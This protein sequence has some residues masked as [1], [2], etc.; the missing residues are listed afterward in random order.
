[1]FVIALSLIYLAYLYGT[2]ASAVAATVAAI[3]LM[4]WL[5]LI[6]GL[7]GTAVD[8]VSVVAVS[9]GASMLSRLS[10]SPLFNVLL[11]GAVVNSWTKVLTITL[12]RALLISGAWMLVHGSAGAASWENFDVVSMIIGGVMVCLGII[13]IRFRLT[14]TCSSDE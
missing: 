11:G 9:I 7:V 13:A 3:S 12:R 10:A 6:V 4:F 1:M 8:A 5:Y 14:A 2:G